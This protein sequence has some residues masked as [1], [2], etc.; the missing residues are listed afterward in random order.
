MIRRPAA[1]PVVE[2][3]DDDDVRRRLRAGQLTRLGGPTPIDK[4]RVAELRRWIARRD[5]EQRRARR[6][7]KERSR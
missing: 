3:L 2:V 7:G 1:D 5:A 6:A 4:A